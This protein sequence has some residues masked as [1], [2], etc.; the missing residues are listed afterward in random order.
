MN[1]IELENVTVVYGGHRALDGVSLCIAA[2]EKLALVGPSG[3]GKSTLLRCMNGLARPDAGAVRLFGEDAGDPATLRRALLRMGTIFQ[4]FN[5]YSNRTALGN[6]T[7][8]LRQ[9]RGLERR[10][11]E[12][13]A[14]E[15]LAEVGVEHLAAK[16]PFQLSGGEQQ[17]VAIAR[18]LAMEPKVLLLDEPTSALDPER[19]QSVLALLENLCAAAGLTV[20]CVTHELAFASRLAGR[21][22]FLEG[23][24]IVEEGAPAALFSRPRSERLRRFLE[25]LRPAAPA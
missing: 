20:V 18:A 6:V 8:A 3:S 12:A 15:R 24:R 21:V 17:R 19:V 5:L 16:Y 4:Q 9:L 2:G 10:H 1:Q 23:G 25:H 13:A 11:A 14:M 7:M 22:V